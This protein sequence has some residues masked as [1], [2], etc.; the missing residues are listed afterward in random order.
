MDG[1]LYDG[2]ALS[3]VLNLP[4]R[5]LNGNHCYAMH[6]WKT[7]TK[8]YATFVFMAFLLMGHIPNRVTHL[9]NRAGVS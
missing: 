2:I 5:F 8:K 7:Q 4:P 9:K 1:T 3:L 6:Q